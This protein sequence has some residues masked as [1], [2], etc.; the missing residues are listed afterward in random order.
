M[1]ENEYI[2]ILKSF[3]RTKKK[4]NKLEDGLFLTKNYSNKSMPRDL[5]IKQLTYPMNYIFLY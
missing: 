3:K 5:F 4:K 2:Y 1:Q